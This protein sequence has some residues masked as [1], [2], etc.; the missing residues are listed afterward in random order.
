[1]E[2]DRRETKFMQTNVYGE[3]GSFFVS[4][5]LRYSSAALAPDVQFYETFAWEW[6]E[7]KKARGAWV[8]DN[9][10][11]YSP[12]KAVEQHREVVDQLLATGK[13]VEKEN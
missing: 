6:D 7:E 10:G 5:I 13:F 4:T 3:H 9:S 2:N 8:A 12:R 1:M 11:A